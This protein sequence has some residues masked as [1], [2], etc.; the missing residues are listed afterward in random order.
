MRDQSAVQRWSSAWFERTRRA[1]VRRV[2]LLA[3]RFRRAAAILVAG[4]AEAEP[5]HHE[6]H[7]KIERDGSEQKANEEVLKEEEDRASKRRRW[8][9]GPST[10]G[11]RRL[12]IAYGVCAV[13]PEKQ[14]GK[15]FNN[16][17]NFGAIGHAYGSNT[18][19]HSTSP[20]A[21][22]WM[23]GSGVIARI[24]HGAG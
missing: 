17:Q 3:R 20:P 24:G 10:A 13:T 14:L 6:K 8:S 23:P 1:P 15:E 4:A 11:G 7:S 5:P 9:R 18:A 12:K 19:S 21:S 2:E 22:R 16:E